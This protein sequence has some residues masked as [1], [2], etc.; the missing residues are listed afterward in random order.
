MDFEART[1]SGQ[2]GAGDA[3]SRRPGAP[4]AWRA[5]IFLDELSTDA[6]VLP[7]IRRALGDIDEDELAFAE[8]A[9][10]YRRRGAARHSADDSA[11]SSAG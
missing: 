5:E 2:A 10:Q 6:A 3:L 7:R 8:E 1:E 11:S 9:E 4:D